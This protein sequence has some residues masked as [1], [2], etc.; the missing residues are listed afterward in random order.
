MHTESAPCAHP[1]RGPVPQPIGFHCGQLEA[2]GEEVA[3]VAVS[4]LGNVW[5][6]D[7]GLANVDHEAAIRPT[8]NL[9]MMPVQQSNSEGFQHPPFPIT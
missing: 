8:Q 3:A 9:A 5:T 2:G 6:A 4:I 1:N 7:Q